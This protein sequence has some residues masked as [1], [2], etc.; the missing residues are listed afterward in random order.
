MQ[1]QGMA[2]LKGRVPSDEVEELP[3]VCNG[4]PYRQ[5]VALHSP[6]RIRAVRGWPWYASSSARFFGVDFVIYVL[7]C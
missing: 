3:S 2:K 4:Y 6:Q 7:H 1:L 5:L